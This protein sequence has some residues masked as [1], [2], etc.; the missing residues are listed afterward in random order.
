MVVANIQ[1]KYYPLKTEV[2]KGS[3][4]T[5]IVYGLVDPKYVAKAKVIIFFLYNKNILFHT[6]GNI[7]NI[8]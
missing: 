5:V 2:E 3:I 8:L 7:V 6:K 4:L 1:N